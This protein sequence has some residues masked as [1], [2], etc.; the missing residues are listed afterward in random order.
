MIFEISVDEDGQAYFNV[1][2]DTDE[3]VKEEK[4]DL[5][6]TYDEEDTKGY[7]SQFIKDPHKFNLEY[8]GGK[9]ILIEGKVIFPKIKEVI[10]EIDL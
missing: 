3:W 1:Y 5:E 10:K 4:K 6:G 2:E 9:R 8:D 7:M